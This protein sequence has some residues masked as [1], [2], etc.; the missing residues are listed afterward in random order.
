MSL[1]LGVT[2]RNITAKVTEITPAITISDTRIGGV[3]VRQFI[4]WA[5]S[6]LRQI[7]LNDI[8]L[9]CVCAAF[10]ANFY[11]CRPLPRGCSSFNDPNKQCC[12]YLFL[13]QGKGLTW[14]FQNIL[15]NTFVIPM[16]NSELVC[17][18]PV[19]QTAE[20]LLGC[21]LETT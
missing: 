7:A 1:V 8:V 14:M 19:C 10:A 16:F 18:L 11:L 15:F 20:S 12:P 21:L 6:W 9:T 5:F 4:C 3:S 13:L 2:G 17:F